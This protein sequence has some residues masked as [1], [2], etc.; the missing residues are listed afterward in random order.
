MKNTPRPAADPGA[1]LDERPGS[2]G[3]IF[4]RKAGGL[5][6]TSPHLQQ[7]IEDNNKNFLLY[8]QLNH[9]TRNNQSF[10]LSIKLM[11]NGIDKFISR[12]DSHSILIDIE[13]R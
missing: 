7:N 6:K 8:F 3:G 2:D 9:P 12:G 1:V 10:G 4:V 13:V 5:V 11:L